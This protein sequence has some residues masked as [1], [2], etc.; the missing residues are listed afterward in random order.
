MLSCDIMLQTK[1][2]ICADAQDMHEINLKDHSRDE[3]QTR[4]LAK[5]SNLGRKSIL[6]SILS[7]PFTTHTCLDIY[8]IYYTQQLPYSPV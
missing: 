5:T 6:S 1:W 3:D 7:T 8:H 4:R 2:S